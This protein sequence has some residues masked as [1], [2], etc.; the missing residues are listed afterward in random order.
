MSQTKTHFQ[1]NI[2]LIIIN[3]HRIKIGRFSF[4]LC[5]CECVCV[6][7]FMSA[8]VCFYACVKQFAR[9]ITAIV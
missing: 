9:H 3:L 4:S 6:C 1:V 2:P 7:V 5:V 8:R